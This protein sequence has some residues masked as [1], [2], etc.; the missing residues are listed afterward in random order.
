MA[1]FRTSLVTDG[2]QID[3]HRCDARA[4]GEKCKDPICIGDKHRSWVVMIGDEEQYR[5]SSLKACK[6]WAAVNIK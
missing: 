5:A 4:A 6:E 3:R 2:Y 1:Y